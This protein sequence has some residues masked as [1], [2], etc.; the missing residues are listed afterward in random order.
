MLKMIAMQMMAKRGQPAMPPT[1]TQ[2]MAGAPGGM[3]PMLMQAL[4]SLAQRGQAPAGM[5][6]MPR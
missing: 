2:S 5:G 6:G 4:M 1:P 3:N